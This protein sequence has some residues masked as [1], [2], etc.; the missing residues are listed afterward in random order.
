MLWSQW[1]CQSTSIFYVFDASISSSLADFFC[2]FRGNHDPFSYPSCK[3]FSLSLLQFISTERIFRLASFWTLDCSSSVSDSF[4]L[5]YLLF[6]EL[7]LVSSALSFQNYVLDSCFV[8]IILAILSLLSFISSCTEF[9][10]EFDSILCFLKTCTKTAL[11]FYFC[12]CWRLKPY[13]QVWKK[14]T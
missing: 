6:S 13:W 9:E 10:S 3:L 7:E 2:L 4:T 11:T 8:L 5:E 14:A 12:S 1:H